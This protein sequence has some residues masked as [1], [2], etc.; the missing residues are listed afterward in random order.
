MIRRKDWLYF[1]ND[2]EMARTD[3]QSTKNIR[4][5]DRAGRMFRFRGAIPECRKP[6]YQ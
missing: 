6:R 2:P 3:L 1:Q 5:E 4:P